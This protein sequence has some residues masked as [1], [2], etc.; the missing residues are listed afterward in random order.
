MCVQCVIARMGFITLELPLG[1][2]VIHLCICKNTNK[3]IERKR[4]RDRET[5]RMRE[6][7]KKERERDRDLIVSSYP[8]R[9]LSSLYI[10]AFAKYKN[11]DI[12]RDKEISIKNERKWGRD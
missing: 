3:D 12:K 10:Y 8:K 5:E 6:K 7:T 1:S 9:K 2:F 11:K 4:D